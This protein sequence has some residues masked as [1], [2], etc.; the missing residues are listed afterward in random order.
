M[1]SPEPGRL[2]IAA[3]YGETFGLE[4][5]PPRPLT[6]D[7]AEPEPFPLDALGP[8]E[9]AAR[10]IVAHTR[11]PDALAGQSALAGSALAVQAHADVAHPATGSRCPMS[12]YM[13]TIAESGE[14]KSQVDRLALM[15][16]RAKEE[17]LREAA[18]EEQKKFAVDK[19]I[20]D[21]NKSAHLSKLRKKPGDVAT[22]ADLRALGPEPE[23]PLTP[24]LMIP[25]PTYEGYVR[26]TAG[27]YPSLGLFSDEGGAFLGGFGMKSE[28]RLKT[29]AA[30]SDLWGGLPI[31]RVRAG[32]GSAVYAGRRLSLHLMAQ[33][34][35]AAGFLGDA[36]LADQGIL[37][38]VL[39]VAPSSTMGTRL[40]VAPS[41]D[42]IRALAAYQKRQAALLEMPLPL[43]PGHRNTLEPRRLELTPGAIRTGILFSN[44]IER[45]LGAE[46]GL[47]PISG[48][49][50]KATEHATR[51]AGVLTL[52]ED[53]EAAAVTD[54]AMERGIALVRH[55]LTEITRLRDAAVIPQE[56]TDAAKL[57]DW[58]QRKWP[59]PAI[60]PV[61]IYKD[62]PLRSLR[63][64]KAAVAAL[65]ILEDHG[66]V[67]E[68]ENG[69][70]IDGRHRAE[71]W[72]IFGRG[73]SLC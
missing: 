33:P 18:E 7:I 56:L 50:A 71:A 68:F 21:A 11:A 2:A 31:K 61:P 43:K 16:V 55:Y 51:L 24:M 14:R 63:N 53:L 67:W 62:G 44:E 70:T 37:S 36:L 29:S 45:Q 28:E 20:Y 46:G 73:V 22:E 25:E 9:D 38:R 52:V 10:A 13:L 39:V 17:Q 15:A 72:G 34:M 69:A 23:P 35:V 60:H 5:E 42:A 58:I 1:S 65:K 27:G 32:D 64:K 30:L 48:F 47:R 8:L 40:H 19:D 6:R 66:Y 12:L 4:Q 57:W 26:L 54:D 49:A 3:A 41:E 59:E